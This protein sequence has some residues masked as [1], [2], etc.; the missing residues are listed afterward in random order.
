MWKKIKNW[1]G[2]TRRSEYIIKYFHESNVRASVYMS[3]IVIAL[4]LWMIES[5]TEYVLTTEKVLTTMWLID[6]YGWY[7]GLLIC[8]VILLIY[9]LAYLKKKTRNRLLGKGIIWMFVLM[10]LAFGFKHGYN[11]YVQG[12]QILAFLTM[13]I[14]VLCLLTWKPV[15]SFV[16]SVAAFGGFYL[17]IDKAQ[18]ATQATQVNLFTMWISCFVVAVSLYHQ[19]LSEA[20]KTE[21]VEKMNEHLRKISTQDE[22]TK[23]HNMRYFRKHAKRRMAHAFEEEKTCTFLYLDMENFKYYNDRYGFHEGDVLLQQ[24][25]QRLEEIF[26]GDLVARFSDDHFVVLTTDEKYTDKIEQARIMLKDMEGEVK[27]ELKTGIYRPKKADQDVDHAC[28]RA[29]IAANSIKKKYDCLEK[30][31]DENLNSEVKWKQYV[32]NNLDEAL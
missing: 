13:A 7:V 21:S 19:R 4:E 3:L 28:D 1:T 20:H 17:L 16:L 10:A 26:Q 6:H 25:A 27:L 30:D 14:F 9:A 2:L 18:P 22:L 29:R 24:F 8:A 23:I 11:S 12:E 5:L 31:Y 32:I 15:V